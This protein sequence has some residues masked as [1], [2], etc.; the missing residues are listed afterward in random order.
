MPV[1]RRNILPTHRW[2][3]LDNEMFQ[4]LQKIMA[5]TEIAKWVQNASVLHHSSVQGLCGQ[6]PHEK[7][8]L[9]LRTVQNL[10][11]LPAMSKRHD[12]EF[13][14]FFC[15]LPSLFCGRVNSYDKRLQM[16]APKPRAYFLYCKN[17]RKHP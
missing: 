9:S 16:D 6:T 3:D 12:K 11:N 7:N 10:A 17:S 1:F 2:G 4:F 8:S 15:L 13:L 14:P 5:Q